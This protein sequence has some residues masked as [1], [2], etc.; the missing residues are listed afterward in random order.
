MGKKLPG[1][2][3]PVV[4]CWCLWQTDFMWG[5]YSVCLHRAA[6]KSNKLWAH[7]QIL[8][9][10]RTHLSAHHW[11]GLKMDLLYVQWLQPSP[12]LESL[13]LQVG[14]C[15]H[16]IPGSWSPW[17]LLVSIFHKLQSLILSFAVKGKDQNQLDLTL[18]EQRSLRAMMYVS[19]EN[20]FI[21]F[22]LFLSLILPPQVFAEVLVVTWSIS[23]LEWER[24]TGWV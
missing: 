24:E 14:P 5:C 17:Q 20:I 19:R 23:V 18:R 13:Y 3:F 11:A 1:Y 6:R 2:G 12:S 7:G 9:T 4:L 15:P 16:V 22:I 8:P 21:V 10:C